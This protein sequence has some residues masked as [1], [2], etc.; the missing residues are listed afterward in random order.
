L[1]FC[2]FQS[3]A[4]LGLVAD[5][6]DHGGDGHDSWFLFVTRSIAKR[7]LQNVRVELDLYV[8]DGTNDR[9]PRGQGKERNVTKVASRLGIH[10]SDWG[11]ATHH[12]CGM[13]LQELRLVARRAATHVLPKN[14]KEHDSSAQWYW[15]LELLCEI[16]HVHH[17]V[18]PHPLGALRSVLIPSMPN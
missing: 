14:K 5:D 8:A 17:P 15:K 2:R 4:R 1:T 18:I 6:S 12:T 16:V 10:D 13:T 7:R 3:A 11:T 9:Q